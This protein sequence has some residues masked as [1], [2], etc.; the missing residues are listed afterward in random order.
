[1]ATSSQNDG[2]SPTIASESAPSSSPDTSTER[3]PTRSTRNPAG[4]WHSAVVMLK[5][6]S[7]RPSLV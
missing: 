4:V 2:I 1:M 7:A 3:A 6:V 5:A